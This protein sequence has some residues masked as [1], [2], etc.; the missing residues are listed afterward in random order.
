VVKWS[1][2]EVRV[3]EFSGVFDLYEERGLDEGRVDSFV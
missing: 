3:I 1:W 2:N